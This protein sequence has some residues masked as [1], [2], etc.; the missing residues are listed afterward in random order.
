[1]ADR[2]ADLMMRRQQEEQAFK[3]SEGKMLV[4]LEQMRQ[5]K[6]PLEITLAGIAFKSS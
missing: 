1:M 4:I 5:N 2:Q 3:L 6:T